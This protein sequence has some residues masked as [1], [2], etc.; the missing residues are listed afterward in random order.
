MKIW[1]KISYGVCHTWQ[2][3]FCSENDQ[4]DC[5]LVFKDKLAKWWKIQK[6][7]LYQ[8]RWRVEKTNGG[9]T[10]KTRIAIF[11]GA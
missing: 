7:C 2:I 4:A 1:H 6:E 3:L 11:K 8:K 9:K 10:I 5:S